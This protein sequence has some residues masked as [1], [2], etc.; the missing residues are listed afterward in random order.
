MFFGLLEKSRYLPD[1]R[2]TPAGSYDPTSAVV[3]ELLGVGAG[4]MALGQLRDG[5]R[6]TAVPAQEDR[7]LMGGDG[8]GITHPPAPVRA[9]WL[10]PYRKSTPAEFITYR[11]NA[12]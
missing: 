7:G 3:P 6:N 5:M 9:K 11:E 10:K 2:R 8:D 1:P 4:V 12:P